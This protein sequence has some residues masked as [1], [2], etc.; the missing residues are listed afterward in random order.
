[1]PKGRAARIG[2]LL[3]LVVLALGAWLLWIPV[4]HAAADP[5]ASMGTLVLDALLSGTF[6]A[7]LEGQLFV[8]I[9]LKFM[10][11]ETL[12]GWSRRSGRRRSD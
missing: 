5:D 4:G 11:G 1:M 2:V 7:G 6:I 10:G 3:A 9:P 12:Y 8:L